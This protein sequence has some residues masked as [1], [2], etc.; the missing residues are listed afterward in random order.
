MFSTSLTVLI[1]EI[2]V[3]VLC[4][5]LKKFTVKNFLDLEVTP[6]SIITTLS[7][8]FWLLIIWMQWL[9]LQQPSWGMR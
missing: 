7:I 2:E 5:V 9:E 4:G 1:S 3:E 6:F 8:S